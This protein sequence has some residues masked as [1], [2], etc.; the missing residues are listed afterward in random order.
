[1]LNCKSEDKLKIRIGEMDIEE[2]EDSKLLGMKIDKKLNWKE[3]VS[4]K[5]GLVSKLNGKTACLKRLSYRIGL[6]KLR[7]VA[8]SFWTSHLAEVRANTNMTENENM[9]AIQRAQNTL[10]RVLTRKKLADRIQIKDMLKTA[11]C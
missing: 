10:L 3:H 11:A 8:D 4:G 1:M 6:T 7:R 2:S 9:K 5:G